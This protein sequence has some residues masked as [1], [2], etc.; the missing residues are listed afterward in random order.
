MESPVT[1]KPMPSSAAELLLDHTNKLFGILYIT[2]TVVIDTIVPATGLW[3]WVGKSMCYLVKLAPI[4]WW[5]LPTQSATRQFPNASKPSDQGWFRTLDAD[6][7]DLVISCPKLDSFS[8]DCQHFTNKMS[9]KWAQ[10]QHLSLWLGGL[11]DDDKFPKAKLETEILYPSSANNTPPPVDTTKSSQ[12]QV[13]GREGA[14]LT[15]FHSHPGETNH[16]DAIQ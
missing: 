15:K 3:S 1:P 2:L 7:P 5:A 8:V 11:Q 4:F 13:D 16:Q 6:T 10:S 14:K 12:A 9:Q